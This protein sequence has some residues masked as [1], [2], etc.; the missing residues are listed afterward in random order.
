MAHTGSSRLRWPIWIALVS[1]AL[2]LGAGVLL[3]VSAHWDGISPGARFALVT[4]LVAMLVPAWLTGEWIVALEERF[5]PTA[6]RV[7]ACGIFLLAL[8]YFTAVRAERL[9]LRRRALAWLGGICLL[10]AP[11]SVAFASSAM[12]GGVRPLALGLRIAGWTVALGLPSI[13]AIVLRRAAA[14]PNLLAVVWVLAL[15]RLRPIGGEILLYA[16]WALGA[17]ALAAWGVWEARNE[18]IDL[19]AAIFA[20]TVFTFYFSEVMDKLGR[21]AS[22]IGLGVLFLA[23]GWAIEQARRRLVLQA[24]GGQA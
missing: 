10:P 14:W 1:G 5:T 16:W 8:A 18:R 2:T 3:F 20:V 21:S 19:G 11:L 7:V 9:D 4:L 6:Y 12:P 17:T 23:G 24:R 15:L 22:L 13:L